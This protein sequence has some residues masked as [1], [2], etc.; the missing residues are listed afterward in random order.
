VYFEIKTE[1][2]KTFLERMAGNGVLFF[3]ISPGIFRMVTHY[4]ITSED[5]DRVLK[6]LEDE[7]S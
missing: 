4:G 6:L 5:I 3:Q 1:N 2:G 7:L